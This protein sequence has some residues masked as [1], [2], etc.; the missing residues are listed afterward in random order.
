MFFFFWG[1]TQ[2]PFIVP[3]FFKKKKKKKRRGVG[4]VFSLSLSVVGG[5]SWLRLL[6]SLFLTLTV[7]PV[8]QRGDGLYPSKVSFSL[9]V[10]IPTSKGHRNRGLNLDLG[11]IHTGEENGHLLTKVLD[12][13]TILDP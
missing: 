8:S 3:N 10:N 13:V 11:E 6:V 9:V 5:F 7:D 4:K 1:Q 12:L 2:G